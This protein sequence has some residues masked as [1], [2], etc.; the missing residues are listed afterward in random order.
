M[1]MTI[2]PH[3]YCSF[4]IDCQ[5]QQREFLIEVGCAFAHDTVAI[6][7]VLFH[8]FLVSFVFENLKAIQS[9]E[10]KIPSTCIFGYVNL[11]NGLFLMDDV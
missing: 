3:G 2:N 1:T 10:F 8:S 4:L 9:Y 7:L 6:L 5:L 11:S